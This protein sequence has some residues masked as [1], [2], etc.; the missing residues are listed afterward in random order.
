M[1]K[2]HLT[3]FIEKKIR[4]TF[5]DQKSKYEIDTLPTSKIS[6]LAGINYFVCE[7][8]LMEMKK[9]GKVKMTNKRK[10]KFWKLI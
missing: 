8:A 6:G 1:K 3:E 9:Q 10:F 7:E 2:Q 5:A 4:E